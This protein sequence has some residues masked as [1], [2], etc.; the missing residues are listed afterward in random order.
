MWETK[1]KF[2]F[3]HYF[4]VKM[5]QA[6]VCLLTGKC[7]AFTFTKI[8]LLRV[9]WDE[10]RQDAVYLGACFKWWHGSVLFWG[11]THLLSLSFGT[12]LLCIRHSSLLFSLW[13]QVELTVLYCVMFV[14]NVYTVLTRQ[15][16][17]SSILFL[18]T[19]F[20]PVLT[21]IIVWNSWVHS[22]HFVHTEFCLLAYNL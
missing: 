17:S 9:V 13:R 6:A 10:S 21:Y 12:V 1:E 22:I 15:L 7:T 2:R 5:G 8:L 20:S 14:K 16:Y 3:W 18:F 11:H 19:C 4:Q